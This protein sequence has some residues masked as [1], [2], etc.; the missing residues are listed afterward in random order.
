MTRGIEYGD[1]LL[2]ICLAMLDGDD[3][4]RKFESLFLTY[5]KLMF[6]V[7]NDILNDKATHF[8][9]MTLNRAWLC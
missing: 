6:H 1:I 9:N 3:E 4:K 8:I 2:P 5:R 7:A